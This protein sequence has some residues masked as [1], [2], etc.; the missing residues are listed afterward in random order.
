MADILARQRQIVGS[1]AEWADND[2]TLGAGELAI[3]RAP[4]GTVR[5][6]VGNGVLPFSAAPYLVPPYSSSLTYIG[7]ADVTAPPP[8]ADPGDFVTASAA[9]TVAASWGPPAA[10]MTVAA[11]QAIA[12]DS[13]GRWNVLGALTAGF[14]LESDLAADSGAGLIGVAS[15]GT[16]QGALDA[17]ERNILSLIPE[18]LHEGIRA[19]TDAS[20]HTAYFSEAFAAGGHWYAPA[21]FYN[22]DDV[23]TAATESIGL[24]GDGEGLS[25]LRFRHGGARSLHF[26]MD[27]VNYHVGVS[28]FTLEAANPAGQC[29][30]GIDIEFPEATSY[31]Y[32]QININSI[33]FQSDLG[34]SAPTWAG[35]W[36]RGIRLRNVWYP[37][38]SGITGLSA[39]IPGT[40]ASTGFLEI[41]GDD[42]ACM[43]PNIDKVV[44]L[45][46]GTGILCSAYTE[47]LRLTN[48]EFVGVTRGLHVPS[49]TPLGGFAGTQRAQALWLSE[50][51]IAA[52]TANIEVDTVLDITADGLNQQ[53][54]SDP[55]AT[56][57][58][59]YRFH[60]V[61]YPRIR[62]GTIAGNEEQAG[63]T[64]VGI[65]ATGNLCAHGIVIGVHFENLDSQFSLDADTTQWVIHSNRSTG[66]RA[67]VF[68]LLG[69]GH[70]VRWLH[71]NGSI[72][73][74]SDSLNG[75]IA[76]GGYSPIFTPAANVDNVG[77]YA[78]RF[79]IVGDTVDVFGRLDIDPTTA[80]VPGQVRISLPVPSNLTKLEQCS[81]V[82]V[83]NGVNNSGT[84]WA[85]PA[86]DQALLSFVAAGATVAG[87]VFQFSYQVA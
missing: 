62:G 30:I 49:T 21:G 84:I 64:T 18:S 43:A 19:G 8:A 67:D 1:A 72:V 17:Q 4:D 85:D 78:A 59:C 73:Y 23:P 80:A 55:S 29:P 57:W 71:S 36:G 27:S 44:W 22:L 34:A 9:G 58:T 31:P 46:G 35:M 69:S 51:H 37:F 33:R 25:F 45:F 48:Y 6:K 75:P 54:W 63:V 2:I 61:S 24:R 32:S 41:V 79:K 86:S 47:G 50:G 74:N 7:N 52:H 15:G 76:T 56:G 14:V 40:T 10:G 13:A 12:K 28:G 11:G 68:T 82:A 53:R 87:W 42:F 70:D 81:G 65:N 26:V 60:Q 39:P 16:V 3:E 83:Q 20:D 77:V 38:I 66:T 5:A